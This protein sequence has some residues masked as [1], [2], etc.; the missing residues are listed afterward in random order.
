MADG[1]APEVPKMGRQVIVFT[2]IIVRRARGDAHISAHADM[3]AG[4]FGTLAGNALF[5]YHE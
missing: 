4:K 1:N 2:W 5:L 3:V